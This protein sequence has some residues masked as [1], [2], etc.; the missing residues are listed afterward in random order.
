MNIR[1]ALGLIVLG[2]MALIFSPAIDAQWIKLPADGIP[3]T[4]D[5]KINMTAPAPRRADGKPDL[6]G[7]WN[8]MN[9]K[10]LNNLAVDFKPGELPILPWADAITK[11]R[12]NDMHGAEES[13]ANCLPPGIPKIN[14]TPNPLKIVQ[15]PKLIVVLYETFGIFRQFFMDGRELRKDPNPSWLGYSIAKWD[16]DTLVV[17]TV[18]FNGKTWLDKVGHPTT[19]STHVTERFRRVDFGHL[20][21]VVTIEDPTAYTKP[22]TV[23][24][25]FDFFPNTELIENVCENEKDIRHMPRN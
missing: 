19:E 10:Y 4:A 2:V 21:S 11:E 16:G 18:G 20:E 24:E 7:I 5:G 9:T 3:R 22:W 12:S 17:D 14:A 1:T 15:E 23:T 25:H 6:S 8:P 13:D